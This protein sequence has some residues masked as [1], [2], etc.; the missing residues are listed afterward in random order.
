M[1]YRPIQIDFETWTKL[2]TLSL[3]ERRS[4]VKIVR[5]LV[6]EKYRKNEKAKAIDSLQK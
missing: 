3:L 4:M 6:E 1:G 2:K 5:D